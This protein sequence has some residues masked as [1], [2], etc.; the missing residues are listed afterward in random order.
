MHNSVLLISQD[1][2]LIEKRK[3]YKDPSEKE[4]IIILDHTYDKSSLFWEH[5]WMLEK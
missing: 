1:G 5:A 4:K 3:A 2:S